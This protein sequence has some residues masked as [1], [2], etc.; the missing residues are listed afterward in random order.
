M[1]V[2]MGNEKKDGGC[3]GV[4]EVMEY[5]FKYQ[6]GE[7]GVINGHVRLPSKLLMRYERLDSATGEQGEE[8]SYETRKGRTRIYGGKV[9]ENVCQAIARCIIGE[10]ML[11]IAKKYRVVLT[12]HDSVVCCV[13]EEEVEEAQQYIESCMRIVPDWATGLPLDC[14]SG[15]GKSYGECE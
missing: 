4:R 14:E 10:Q 13:P 8:F 6:G 1:L 5:G 12:V 3:F 7:I 2:D 15:V 11:D 9:I